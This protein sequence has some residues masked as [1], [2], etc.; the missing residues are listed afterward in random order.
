MTEP[1]DKAQR[2]TPE[3]EQGAAVPDGLSFDPRD[4]PTAWSLSP[5]FDPSVFDDLP[6]DENGVPV[7]PDDFDR[8]QLPGYN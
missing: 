8:S 7:L 5:S 3:Q 2:R 1:H 4:L 6:L